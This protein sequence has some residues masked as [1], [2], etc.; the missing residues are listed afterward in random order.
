MARDVLFTELLDMVRGEAMISTNASLN[1]N[2]TPNLKI[3]VQRIQRQLWLNYDWKFM[4]GWSDKTVSAGQRYYDFPTDMDSNRIHQVHYRWN[5]QFLEICKGISPLDYNAFDSENATPQRADPVMR[6]DYRSTNN[7]QFEIHPIPA[8]NG[9]ASTGYV[10]FSGMKNLNPLVADSDRCTLDA[11][12]IALYA[13]A[14]LLG[15]RSK[16]E[17]DRK[18]RIANAM[19]TSLKGQYQASGQSVGTLGGRGSAG[20]RQTPRFGPPLVAVDRGT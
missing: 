5:N 10:R 1:G 6:W 9:T 8:T 4:K 19:L 12:L 13:A 18:L 15:P 14:E 20:S 17:A 7:K 2:I 3:I 11:D 16:D